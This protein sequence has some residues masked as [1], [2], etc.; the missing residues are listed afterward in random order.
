MQ[1]G[2]IGKE[3]NCRSNI[4][5]NVVNVKKEYAGTKYRTLWECYRVFRGLFGICRLGTKKEFVLPWM[6]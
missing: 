1:Y 2:V 5:W 3:S 4:V 6:R